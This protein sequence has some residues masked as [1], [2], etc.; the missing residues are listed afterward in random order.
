MA[1]GGQVN[2][3]RGEVGR[4]ATRSSD[5]RA[6]T[7]MDLLVSLAVILILIAIMLPSIRR[8]RDTAVQ[9]V[10]GSNIRQQGLGLMM[11]S[12]DYL[13]HFPPTK[14]AP[15][16]NASAAAAIAPR[17]DQMVIVRVGDSPGDWDGLGF[18]FASQYLDAPRV[19]YCP[20]HRGDHPGTRYD[21]LWGQRTGQIVSNFQYRGPSRLNAPGET[22]LV[23]DALRTK[24]DFSH[25]V[26]ANVLRSDFSVLWI[27]D[28][29]RQVLN[30]LP[31]TELDDEA[32][33]KVD[34]AWDLIDAEVQAS[35]K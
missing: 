6:F 25:Q 5:G 1:G 11:Y 30:A 18:L 35:K 26:G 13:D 3:G 29:D 32:G 9:V 8:A 10:C 24:R 22:A 27:S 28:A 14:F 7:L 31:D 19:F 15:P 33:T 16:H 17:A 2:L 12:Q 23:A 21:A 4:S 20:A 34:A